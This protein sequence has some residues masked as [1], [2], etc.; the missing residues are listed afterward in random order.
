MVGNPDKVCIGVD[1]FSEFGGPRDVFMPKFNE[2]K[3]SNHEFYE[4]DF[5]TYFEKHTRKIGVY[6]YDAL[7]NFEAQYIG[8]TIAEPYFS[9]GC[10]IL[11]D[12]WNWNFVREATNRFLQEREGYQIVLEKR[13]E[14][15]A[16]DHSID[17]HGQPTT[18]WNGLLVVKKL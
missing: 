4:M 8:L 6:Y 18:F 10:Y 9:T 7:H 5:R 1:N 3:S 13:T 12:D 17:V 15:S 14:T 16:T 11:V 2:L